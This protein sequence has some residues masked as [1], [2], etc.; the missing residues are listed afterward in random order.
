M[1]G[2]T[3]Q[4]RTSLRQRKN[5]GTIDKEMEFVSPRDD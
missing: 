1:L 4:Q 5:C 3:S 2:M